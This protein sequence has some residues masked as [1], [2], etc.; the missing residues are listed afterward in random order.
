MHEAAFKFTGGDRFAT[1]WT[2]REDGRD[3]FTEWVSLERVK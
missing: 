3:V 2:W 1:A